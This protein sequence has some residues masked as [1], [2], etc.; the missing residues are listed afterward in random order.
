MPAQMLISLA[1]SCS[2]STKPTAS[3]QEAALCS[4]PDSLFPFKNISNSLIAESFYY[5]SSN[6]CYTDSTKRT[7]LTPL[8]TAQKKQLI[9]SIPPYSI[10]WIIDDWQMYFVSKQEKMG[11]FTPIIVSAAGTDYP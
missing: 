6:S 1:A 3:Y 5:D 2:D 11:S 10:N 9:D 4:L 8:N 7:K